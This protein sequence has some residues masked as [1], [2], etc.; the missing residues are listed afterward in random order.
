MPDREQSIRL[1]TI[2][3]VAE[4]LMVK[5][6]T[7]YSWVRNGSI[8]CHRLNGL[9]RFDLNEIEAWITSSR[10]STA[11]LPSIETMK[12]T[13]TTIDNIIRRAIDGAKGK[14]YNSP[15]GKPGQHDGLRKE[16]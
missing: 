4:I 13:G 8:P 5:P 2:K 11:T 1:V 15:N 14:A 6:S 10:T 7:L 12:S 16:G 3:V 9:I